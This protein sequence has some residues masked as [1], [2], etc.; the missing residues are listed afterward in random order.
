M[1]SALALGAVA[2]IAAMR[3]SDSMPR[4]VDTSALDEDALHTTVALGARTAT[5][6]FTHT[7]V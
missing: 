5:R 7:L 4:R 3:P 6:A 2:A 1:M